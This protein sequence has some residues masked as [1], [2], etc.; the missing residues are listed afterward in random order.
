LGSGLKLKALSC[1]YALKER[2]YFDLKPC[3]AQN[4]GHEIACSEL[5]WATA[6]A[7]GGG[8]VYV[9][10]HESVGRIEQ[11]CTLVNGHSSAVSDI[12]FS[13]FQPNLMATASQDCSV[14][15]W[16][17][18]CRCRAGLR[19]WRVRVYIMLTNPLSPPSSP[20]IPSLVA[21]RG[22]PACPGCR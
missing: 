10:R 6:Y 16:Q 15:L 11:D 17:V 1:K 2:S 9:S 13:P 4:D 21:K 14:K 18:R 3:K 8:P 7:G 12:A 20:T 5:F 22:S 19:I